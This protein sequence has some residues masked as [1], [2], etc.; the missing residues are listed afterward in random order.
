MIYFE[1]R[2]VVGASVNE[3]ECGNSDRVRTQ[4][5]RDSDRRAVP[6]RP[7]FASILDRFLLPEVKGKQFGKPRSIY[8]FNWDSVREFECLRCEP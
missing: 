8:Q 7:C 4:R 3:G 1:R 6:D 5:R 2:R